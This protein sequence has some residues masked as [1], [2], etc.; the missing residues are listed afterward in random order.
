MELI[1]EC[2]DFRLEKA[3]MEEVPK[4]ALNIAKLIGLDEKFNEVI[5]REYHKED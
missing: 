1:Q 3:S 5:S 4:D 2:M